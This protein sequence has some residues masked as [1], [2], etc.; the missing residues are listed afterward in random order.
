MQFKDLWRTT[1]F[2]LTIL[3]G[4][5]FA[6]GTIALLW[7]IYLRSAVY[8]TSRV[9]GILNT[10]AEGTHALAATGTAPAG[11]RRADPERRSHQ[12]LRLFTAAGERITG[13]LDT[14]PSALGTNGR[15]LEVPPTREFRPARGSWQDACR[16][17]R[18]S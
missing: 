9:D 4:G 16:P 13:N 17:A 14:I 3:Y 11:H 2:R 15:P 10:E 1:T 6:L 8:L 7:L 18:S 12:R 5:L